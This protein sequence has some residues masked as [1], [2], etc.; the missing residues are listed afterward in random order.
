MK[1]CLRITAFLLF[2]S[3]RIYGQDP[4]KS[5]P[6][7][8][9]YRLDGKPFSERSLKP[10][11]KALFVFFD[12]DC[13]HCQ[14]AAQNLDKNYEELKGA[15]L[16]LV[17]IDNSEKISY[18]M[19]K[20]CPKLIKKSNVTILQDTGSEF[21]LKFK[22]RKYPSMLLFS[23]KGK[24]LVYSDDDEHMGNIFHQLKKP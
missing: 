17:T 4:V 19:N 14:H 7:F 12:S 10:G 5:I 23:D 22:P 24:L 16:Y 18:F 1:F 15:S 6:N 3:F 11:K 21:I 13:E 20:F 9:F 2:I 8:L